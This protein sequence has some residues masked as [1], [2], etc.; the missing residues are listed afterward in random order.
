MLYI[1]NIEDNSA[2]KNNLDSF[3]SNVLGRRTD[4][5]VDKSAV[6]IFEDGSGVGASQYRIRV[7]NFGPDATTASFTITDPQPANVIFVSVAADADWNC[8][9]ITPTLSCSHIGPSLAAVSYTHMR[10]PTIDSV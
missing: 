4:L 5:G 9:S 3:E 7:T 10:L 1:N 2:K 8:S 6:G